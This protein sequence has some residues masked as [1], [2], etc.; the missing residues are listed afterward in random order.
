MN[1][2]ESISKAARLFHVPASALRYWDHEGLIRF[3]RDGENGYRRLTLNTLMDISEVMLYREMSISIKEIREIPSKDL[4]GLDETF[5]NNKKKIEDKIMDWEASLQKLAYKQKLLARV[6]ELR[7]RGFE[8]R[9]GKLPAVERFSFDDEGMV[10]AFREDNNRSGVLVTFEPEPKLFYGIFTDAA[11]GELKSSDV[12]PK[13]YLNGLL[14]V[15]GEDWIW[16]NGLDFVREA[17]RLGYRPGM[18]YGRFLISACE[19]RRYDYYEGWLEL[20]APE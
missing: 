5:Q 3:E 11:Q 16:H 17:E 12:K 14:L 6:F 13:H 19:E 20:L 18:L 9:Y 1:E 8:D 7:K 4:A 2:K 10:Q 15:D